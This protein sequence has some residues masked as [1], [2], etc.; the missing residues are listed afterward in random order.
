MTKFVL[1]TYILR[2]S[3]KSVVCG[4]TGWSRMVL[5]E[6]N[7]WLHHWRWI[8][9]YYY[10]IFQMIKHLLSLT[11]L[12][13][14]LF[15]NDV[16]IIAKDM[17]VFMLRWL[18]KFPQ[19]KTRDLFLAGES[20]AGH[21]IPQLADVILEYNA[22]RSNRFKFNLK[23]IAVSNKNKITKSP[24]QIFVLLALFL[25][26]SSVLIRSGIRFWSL[27]GIFQQCMSSFGPMG[28]YLMNLASLSWTNAT[29]KITHSQI[30]T[31]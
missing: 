21:Y 27:T 5:F 18:E 28:W 20:Y 24:S 31:T 14:N 17:L 10:I 11:R 3:L 6:H 29:L 2:C 12:E 30:H 15:L 7:F 16:F 23:G 22:R 8:H 26:E 1:L 19:F 9:W 4:F 25:I 13:K